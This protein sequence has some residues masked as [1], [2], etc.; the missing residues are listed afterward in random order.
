[1]DFVVNTVVKVEGIDKLQ[2]VIYVDRSRDILGHI[3]IEGKGAAPQIVNY[4]TWEK[5]LESG[6][7]TLT[8]DPRSD[9]P[10]NHSVTPSMAVRRDQAWKIIGGLVKSISPL[11]H[12]R[13]RRKLIEECAKEYGVHVTTVRN[14]L[15]EY[16]QNG[17]TPS[18]LLGHRNKAGGHNKDSTEKAPKESQVKRGAPRTVAQGVGVNVT[19]QMRGYIAL[20]IQTDYRK[21]KQMTYAATYRKMIRQ[22]IPEA[23]EVDGKGNI[24]ITKPE[25]VPTYNQF[26]YYARK[27][28]DEY[29]DALARHGDVYAEQKFRPLVGN[30]TDA[31]IG[32]GQQY[33]IDATIGDFYLVSQLDRQ[34]PIGRPIVYFVVDTWSRCIVGMHIGLEYPAWN[35][36]MQALY[37]VTQD[38]VKYCERYGVVIEAHQWPTAGLPR[39]IV[40]DRAEMLSQTTDMVINMLGIHIINIKAYRGDLKAVVERRFGLV[41]A[42]LAPEAPGYIDKKFQPRIDRDYRLDAAWTL[43]EFTAAVIHA[44]IVHNTTVVGRYPLNNDLIMDQVA[45]IP[46]RLWKWGIA[47]RTG[48]LIDHNP[49]LIALA[50]LP[51]AYATVTG[52]GIRFNSRLYASK[53]DVVLNWISTARKKRFKLRATFHFENLNAILVHDP[54]NNRAFEICTLISEESSAL[55]L[56]VEE[57]S[58][59]A[60]LAAKTKARETWDDEGVKMTH[61]Q[62][63]ADLTRAAVAKKAAQGP[64]TRSKQEKLSNIAAARAFEITVEKVQTNTRHSYETVEQ[65]KSTALKP[66]VKRKRFALPLL[67]DL[68]D[69]D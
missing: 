29:A 51:N 64:D 48:A 16:F 60:L 27:D 69:D 55:N 31:A 35:V 1:M 58:A 3:N 24:N 22:F 54:K 26:T 45:A 37:N 33:Q 23:C 52:E 44:V 7:I 10:F 36:A 18:A 39:S 49:D 56:C 40:G 34:Q 15:V 13:S 19:E 62:A 17:S 5:L 46:A 12:S 66:A 68:D 61:E 20:A 14:Y 47:N 63:I 25:L 41:Q 32:P 50:L 30:S 8:S 42:Q 57:V 28:R 67:K 9:L 43:P 38:K 2:R 21:N 11:L 53:S 6:S 4:S 59:I 65:P